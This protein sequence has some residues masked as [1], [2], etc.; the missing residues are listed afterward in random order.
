M[1]LWKTGKCSGGDFISCHS[2]GSAAKSKNR[3]T[4]T[5]D[6]DGKAARAATSESED[7]RVQSLFE[8][9]N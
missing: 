2:E 6:M 4:G 7:E 3:A 8:K 5:R 9:T 1:I